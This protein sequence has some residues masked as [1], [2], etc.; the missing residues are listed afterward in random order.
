MHCVIVQMERVLASEQK[1]TDFAPV[2]DAVSF[3]RP[4]GACMMATAML[5]ALSAAAED[6]LDGSSL[7]SFHAEVGRNCSST[8]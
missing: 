4:T 7:A 5:T 8:P 6:C 2:D 3:D 1:R